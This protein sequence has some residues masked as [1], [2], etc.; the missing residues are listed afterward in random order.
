MWLR[1][2]LTQSRKKLP[3]H[4]PD[5]KSPPSDSKS[6]TLDYFHDIAIRYKPGIYRG[7][8]T[9]FAGKDAK[10]FNHALLWKHFVR[11]RVQIIRVGGEHISLIS[12]A[13]APG[14]A[15]AFKQALRETQNKG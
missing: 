3:V 4:A 12:E 6:A 2:H 9:I 14:L 7:D 10:P 8:V 5:A 11:G 15:E 13:H 1:V